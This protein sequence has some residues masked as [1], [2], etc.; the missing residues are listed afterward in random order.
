MNI[1][2]N[3]SQAVEKN[4]A[5]SIVALRT[6]WV[7]EAETHGPSTLD[8]FSMGLNVKNAPDSMD[9]FVFFKV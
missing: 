9:P 6:D 7:A 2:N 3:S 1:T 8:A 5:G 4:T